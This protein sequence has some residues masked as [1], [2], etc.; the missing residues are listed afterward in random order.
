MF[1]NPLLCKVKVK[2]SRV[3][4]LIRTCFWNMQL[5]RDRSMLYC[6]CRRPYDQRP[7]IACDKCDE[8]YHF[9]CIKLS[10]LPKIYICPACCCM[11][12]EDFA[13][14]STSGEEKWAFSLFSFT[15]TSNC[16]KK[17]AH[18]CSWKTKE[19]RASRGGSRI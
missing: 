3:T 1:R 15:K 13:S 6:I 12:G 17:I 2:H 14:T 7:M 16:L 11:E 18:W 5:L 9:D 8:W 19:K 4:Q 10:S